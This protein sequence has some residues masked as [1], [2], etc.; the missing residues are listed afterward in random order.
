MAVKIIK[1]DF[2]ITQNSIDEFTRILAPE[3]RGQDV[4]ITTLK[5]DESIELLLEMEGKSV[6]VEFENHIDRL[7]DQKI[8]MTKSGILKLYEKYYPWGALTGVR[9]TKLVRKL[10][11]SGFDY[12]EIG[13]ILEKLYLV[14]SEKRELLI[15]VVRKEMEYLNRDYINMYIGIPYCPT[16]CR[17][18]SFASYELKGK[19][20]E[21]YDR[22]VDALIEEI[23]ITGRTLRE[24]GY[25][26]ES[27]YIGGGTPSILSESDLERVL[28]A[29]G[30]HVDLSS[31]KE[32]T[33]EAGRVDTL[34]DD[35]LEIMKKYCVDRISLNP[36][37]FNEDTLQSL[38][39]KFDRKKFDYMF[40]KSK[41][42]GFIIN[43]DLIIG[44]PGE[45]TGDILKTLNDIEEYDMDNLTV[46]VLALKK[47]SDL[48]KDEIEREELDARM[49]EE[50]IAKIT[51]D[52][53]LNPYYMY[54]Q[55][56][57]IDWGENIGYAKDGTESIF[58]IE[59]IEENQST[60]GLGGG[61]IT[62]LIE[63]E[64]DIRDKITRVVNPKDPIRYVEELEER[65]AKKLELFRKK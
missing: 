49:I 22:F 44:L 14:S 16:K 65:L 1:A 61:A 11:A 48:Y 4:K 56:N 17:Y 13:Y 57:S 39:R 31:V 62:K 10:L 18:C 26:L 7:D 46:H 9:P 32:F 19:M 60:I 38:N 33:L 30:E 8:V 28:F 21:Y 53:G 47:A 3:A 5:E 34:S 6:K 45:T 58:N 15:S 29:V 63:A 2:Y 42:L 54:R 41:E 59:M 20:G 25:R 37:T 55:K 43:M 12:F 64:T 52:K 36:Q 50:K 23:K 40:Q 35:K 27:L 24:N 51:A